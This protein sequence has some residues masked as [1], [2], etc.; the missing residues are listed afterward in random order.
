MEINRGYEAMALGL[1]P[2]HLPQVGDLAPCQF[3]G[4]LLLLAFASSPDS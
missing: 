4:R 1:P 3:M 2:E